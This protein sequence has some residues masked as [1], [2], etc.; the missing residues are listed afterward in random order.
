MGF[1]VVLFVFFYIKKFKMYDIK[2]GKCMERI[3]EV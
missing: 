1:N 3:I 2:C